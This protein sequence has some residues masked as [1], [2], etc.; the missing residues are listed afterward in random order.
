MSITTP[1]EGCAG[2]EQPNVS[3]ELRVGRRQHAAFAGG[4]NLVAKEAEGG[5]VAEGADHA[6]VD[7]GAE[8]LSGILDDA[9]AEPG[10]DGLEG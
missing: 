6:A 3:I 10:T 2:A 8:C 4:Q 7:L 1:F 9:D 5:D